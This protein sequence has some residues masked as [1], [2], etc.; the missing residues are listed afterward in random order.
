LLKRT[1]PTVNVHVLPEGNI[2]IT[3]YLAFRNRLRSYPEEHARY[4]AAKRN[5]AARTWAYVQG[6]ADAKTTVVEEIIGR[7][8][9]S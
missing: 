5:L 6:Y 8:L 3:R 7:T 1:G 9:G 4:E 2:E